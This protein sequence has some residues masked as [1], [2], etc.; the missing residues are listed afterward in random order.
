MKKYSLIF[1]VLALFLSVPVVMAAPTPDQCQ[2]Y[3]WDPV[4][5]DTDGNDISAD[6]TGYRIYYGNASGAYGAPVDVG[7]VLTVAI[8]SVLPAVPGDYYAALTATTDVAES[9]YS[10]E[11]KLTYV[12]GVYRL[13]G[14]PVSPA[15]FRVQ[16][17]VVTP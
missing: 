8:D 9:A 4:T 3:V 5:K 6:I 17:S 16:C 2:N 12:D 13:G 15:P 1:V 10:S 7:N 14:V 11:I